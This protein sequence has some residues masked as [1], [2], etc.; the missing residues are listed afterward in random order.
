MI[1]K[2]HGKNDFLERIKRPECPSISVLSEELGIPK[3]TL[4]AWKSSENRNKRIGMAKKYSKR[5]PINKFKLIA[6]SSELNGSE[7]QAFC[8]RNGVSLEELSTWKDLAL[9]AIDHT[10]SGAVVSKKAHDQEVAK[11]DKEL[12]RKNDALAEAAALLIL[13]KKTSDLF[14]DEK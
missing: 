2:Y 3:T 1:K 10:E 9:S 7:L 4:Y 13:Q 14:R 12:R 11:L 8:D 6:D 5:S